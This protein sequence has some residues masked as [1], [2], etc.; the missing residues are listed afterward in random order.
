VINYGFF[1]LFA[2]L[3]SFGFFRLVNALLA[4]ASRFDIDCSKS[5]SL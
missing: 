5:L 2:G 1:C 3:A 4:R